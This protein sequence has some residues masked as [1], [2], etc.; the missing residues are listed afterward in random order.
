RALVREPA[1]ELGRVAEVVQVAHARGPL[2]RDLTPRRPVERRV[3][4]DQVQVAGKV[5]DRVE[6]ARP[7]LRVDH[8]LPVGVV[9]AGDADADRALTGRGHRNLL[10][11]DGL[12]G[13]CR[14]HPKPDRKAPR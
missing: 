4:L 6:V 2:L 7:R 3:D 9:P 8:T 10:P 5:A 13:A 14:A 1:P 11:A 12:R